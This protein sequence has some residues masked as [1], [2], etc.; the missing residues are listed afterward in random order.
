MPL[1]RLLGGS[2]DGRM[3]A[4]A[5]GIN[6]DRAVR[7]GRGRQS[8]GLSRLQAE[9]RLRRATSI[10]PTSP[11]CA[12]RLGPDAPIAVDANQAWE[13]DEAIEMSRALARYAPLWLE[14]PIAADS[15]VE[16][17]Q[18]LAE[19]SPVPLAAGENLR[20]DAAFDAAIACGRARASSSPISPN[21]AAS[22][23]ACR[24]RG[25]STARACATARII[26]AAASGSWPRRICWRRPAATACSR[27]TATPIRCARV[28]RR[29]SRRSR[30]ASSCCREQPGLGVAPGPEVERFAITVQAWQ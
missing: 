1:W 11:R 25:A 26:W 23:P 9:D 6:P 17:W 14:E 30:T 18:R 13:L 10:S 29:P 16:D 19:A 3:P 12:P 27:S 24:S 7:A 15:P 4:Y 21:G 2:G 5:S 28:L 20:G 22:R 8:R